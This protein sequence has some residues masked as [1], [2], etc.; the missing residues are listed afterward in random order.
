MHAARD[1]RERKLLQEAKEGDRRA[2]EQ[3]IA[4]Y[5]GLV[6]GMATRYGGLGLAFEDMLQEGAIGLLEAIDS[7]DTTR[8]ASFETFARW[9]IRHAVTDALTRQA[10]LV[11]LP[12]RVVERRRA[13]AKA[14][15]EL[16]ARTGRAPTP[17]EITAE[18]G[19]PVD[20]IE[21]IQALPATTASLDQPV[22]GDGA[23]I[24]ELVEDPT[25]IDPEAEAL[26]LDRADVIGEALER[27][28]ER[29]RQ[30]IE[31][32]FGFKGP[33][34]S[35]VE[36]SR[37]LHLCPQRTRSLEQTALFRLAKMLECDPTFQ[38][39]PR[40]EWTVRPPSRSS[41]VGRRR[42]SGIRRRRA[43][44]GRRPSCAPTRYAPQPRRQRARPSPA[45]GRR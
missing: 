27:L 21:A 7:F 37:E 2:R 31:H 19:L 32:R 22:G 5:A 44:A 24:L 10:R 15:S 13:V 34:L 41:R 38:R 29:E 28:P 20:S 12:K 3:L 39:P 25:S 23:T 45:G 14:A 42:D 9:H 1:A 30:V 16:T 6:R 4:K 43:P 11:R 33:A 36:V 35:L 40:S 17:A 18:T 26:A 8:G